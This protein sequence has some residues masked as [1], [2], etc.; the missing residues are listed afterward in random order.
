MPRQVGIERA[1]QFRIVCYIAVV[2]RILY[3]FCRTTYRAVFLELLQA[4]VV[5]KEAPTDEV[6]ASTEFAAEF[7]RTLH[8]GYLFEELVGSI[9]IFEF[10]VCQLGT[11]TY[12]VDPVD[13]LLRGAIDLIFAFSGTQQHIGVAHQA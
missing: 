10:Q 4:T 2:H 6:E 12:L 13:S 3:S 5:I 8:I 9:E 1:L 11:V 7:L